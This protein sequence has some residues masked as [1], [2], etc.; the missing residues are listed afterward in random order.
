MADQPSAGIDGGDNI[1][2]STRRGVEVL[3]R[4]QATRLLTELG[5]AIA[6]AFS[7]LPP[8]GETDA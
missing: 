1:Y 5:H 6:E 8:A 3:T 2:L 7:P 4:D